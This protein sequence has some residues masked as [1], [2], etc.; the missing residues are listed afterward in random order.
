MVSVLLS[1]LLSMTSFTSFAPPLAQE[2]KDATFDVRARDVLILGRGATSGSTYYD[3]VI[4][5]Q[6]SAG[7]LIRLPYTRKGAKFSFDLHQRAAL[8][9]DFTPAE[10]T[11]IIEVVTGATTSIGNYTISSKINPGDKFDEPIVKT[12]AA[13]IDQYVTPLG[14]K[15]ITLDIRPGP[16]SI[17]IVGKTQAITRGTMTTRIDTPG[18]RI[19]TVSNFKFEAVTEINPLK[20]SPPADHK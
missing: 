15:T 8:T 19:A 5:Q 14:R 9:P 2:S 13:Q 16:Q 4:T 6:A 3:V 1:F 11:T 7:I 12:P 17:S 20:K 18:A 10:V